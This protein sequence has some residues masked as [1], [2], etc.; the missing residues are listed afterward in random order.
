MTISVSTLTRVAVLL[1]VVVLVVVLL[2][3]NAVGA[4]GPGVTVYRDHRVT[5]GDTLWDIAAGYTPAG[6]DV[7]NTIVGIRQASD[8]DGSVIVP[9]QLLRIPLS[10]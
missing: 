8:L 6:E 1:T 3:A 7:R 2:L 9:G 10:G 5:S 4:S